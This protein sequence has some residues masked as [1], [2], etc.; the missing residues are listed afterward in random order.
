MSFSNARYTQL[1]RQKKSDANLSNAHCSTRDAF[2]FTAS[3]RLTP[4][5]NFI[6]ESR[7]LHFYDDDDNVDYR[8]QVEFVKLIDVH[9]K[10]I[11]P[12]FWTFRLRY[13]EI[14]QKE[15]DERLFI[16]GIDSNDVYFGIQRIHGNV[17]YSWCAATHSLW[18][19]FFF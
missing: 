12:N 10:L 17:V 14:N 8:M 18:F 9:S 13:R 1:A 4:I 16:L 15:I 11:D 5:S 6:C 2:F 19:I 3:P 7:K